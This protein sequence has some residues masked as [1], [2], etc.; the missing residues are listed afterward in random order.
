MPRIKL[1]GNDIEIDG[2]KVAR[3][4]DI[5]PALRSNLEDFINKADD[6]KDLDNEVEDLIKN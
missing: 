3:V 5:Y 2:Q 6:Y 1:I 4:L